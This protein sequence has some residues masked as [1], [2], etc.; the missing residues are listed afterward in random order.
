MAA[1]SQ[2]PALGP[3]YAKAALGAVLPRRARSLP[4]TELVREDVAV[5]LG[6]LADYARVCGFTLTGALPVTYPH[7]LAFGQQVALMAQRAFPLPLPGLVHVRNR[8]VAARRIDAGERLRIV[9]RAERFGPHPKGAQVDLVAE[10][11][12]AGEPVWTGRSTYLSRG[13]NAPVAAATPA[14][15]LPDLGARPAAAVWRVSADTGRRYAAV[16]GDVNPIHLHPL[17]ARAFGFPTAIAHGMWTAARAL[18]SLQGRIGDAVGYD[19]EF[20]KPLRLPSTVELRSAA[21]DGGWD[22]AV[23]ARSG[24][25]HLRATVRE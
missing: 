13:A 24:A 19:A 9:V 18:A 25:E 8:I 2:A 17:A 22:V 10:V 7:V 5:D 20:R 4:R 23:A 21:V 16:S 6:H 12:V 11:T 1:P 14:D 3:L 15:P